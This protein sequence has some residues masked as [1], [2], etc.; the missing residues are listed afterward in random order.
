MEIIPTNSSF[1]NYLFLW[2]GQLFSLFG[3]MIVSFSIAWWI[4]IETGSPVFLAISSTLYIVSNV[5]ILPIA[6]VFSDRLKKKQVII[7]ADSSQVIV[8]LVLIIFFGLGLANIYF[9]F[10]IVSLRSVFQAI[11]LPTANS[12]IPIMVPKEKLTRINGI[13]YLFTGLVEITAPFVGAALLVI[14][15]V[16]QVFWLDIFT[17]AI[18][19][20]PLLIVRIP[21]VN[22][23]PKEQKKS[24]KRDFIIGFKTLRLIPGFLM[25]LILS[26]FQNALNRPINALLPY[27]VKVIHS[28]GVLDLAIVM[29]FMQGSSFVG[30][31]I[32]SIKKKW[33]HPMNIYFM[34]LIIAG[35]GYLMFAFVP[36]GL[37]PIIGI[38]AIIYTFFIP[39]VNSLYM[40]MVQT[41]VPKDKIG[42]IISI[43]YALSMA[44]SPIATL[45]SG[46][47]TE[48]I[49]LLNLII[50][51]AIIGIALT[52]PVWL[53]FIRNKFD[54]HDEI[55][56]QKVK[57]N[58]EQIIME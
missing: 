8:T 23:T 12:I 6:G 28:G 34:G 32:T 7:F 53:F 49:G 30:A 25:I 47:L 13:N 2:S 41:V 18:A 15:T 20:I 4:T 9:L 33:S 21:N 31:M 38:A 14:F 56:I 29:G 5:V 37:I 50:Y 57:T 36:K 1:R 51:C 46:F 42:R 48:I 22:M 26:M 17:F 40:T 3:S 24:F 54:Y 11:H 10:L 27:Y 16:S 58:L 19:L 35:V 55:F 39:I 45:I 52:F 44:I 43:D